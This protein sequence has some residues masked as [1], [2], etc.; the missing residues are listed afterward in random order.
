MLNIK[1]KR[2]L[3]RVLINTACKK[4]GC[5]SVTGARKVGKTILFL[6]LDEYFAEKSDY[7][8]C[9]TLMTDETFDFEQYYKKAVEAG[10]KILFLDEVCKINDYYLADFIKYTKIYSANL[11]IMLTGS[12]ATIVKKRMNEIGRGNN[13]QLPPFLY[14]EKLCWE[15]GYEEIDLNA[16]RSL[17][18]DARFKEYLKSQMMS[19][20]ELLGYMQGVV[21]DTIDS[22]SER[23][24][25]E[26]NERPDD[27]TLMNALKYIALCQFVYKKKSGEYVVIPSIEKK[28]RD[29]IFDDYKTAKAKWGLTN[30]DIESVVNLLLGC[31]LARKVIYYRGNLI[32]IEELKIVDE[33]VPDIIFEYPWYCSVC[34][35]SVI[36]ESDAI[37]DQW[38]EYAVLIRASYIYQYVNKFRSSDDAEFDVLYMTDKYYGVEV[39]NK[40]YGNNSGAYIQRIKEIADNIGLT[41]HIISSSDEVYRNDKII[42]CM[43]LEY[44]DLLMHE[45]LHSKLDICKL[46]DKYG[47]VK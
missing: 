25:L 32:K 26:D 10:R 42:S 28:I 17:T 35:D 30:T 46:M 31:N 12:V 39:K 18:T 37:M 2:F 21:E 24:F 9:T 27:I 38:V 13:Y 40:P 14:I 44:I 41:G 43:E 15:N 22:Y 23:T 6:Q 45:E 11:C 19:P 16:I 20:M 3:Y 36:Q 4:T 1:T 7:F 29:I 5:F 34:F 8:D 47:F 33:N